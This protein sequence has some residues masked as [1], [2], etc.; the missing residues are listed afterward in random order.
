M[1]AVRQIIE[2]NLLDG[3][4]SLPK[5]FYNR[6]VEVIVFLNEEKPVLPSLT[7]EDIDDMLIGSITESMVGALPFSE[8]TLEDYRIERF[9]LIKVRTPDE[10]VNQIARKK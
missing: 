5:G 9:S 3:V 7:I 2:S 10:F 6:K 1:E 8:K 4:I